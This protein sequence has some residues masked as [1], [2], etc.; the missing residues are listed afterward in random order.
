MNKP[1]IY[2]IDDLLFHLPQN[3]PE[4][5]NYRYTESLLPIIESIVE[6][7]CVTVTTQNLKN[8]VQLF[9]KN[10]FVLPNYFD[11]Y[12]WKLKKPT[13]EE[14]TKRP[15]IIGYMGT[16]THEED[17]QYITPVLKELLDRY[18]HEIEIHFWGVKPSDDLMEF[19]NIKWHSS[20]TYNYVEFANYFQN[21]SVDIFI[22]PLVDNLF[23]RS[24]SPLK[25]FEYSSLGTPSV[26][27]NLDPFENIIINKYNG[28][29]ASNHHEWFQQLSLLIEND[30]LRYTI[31]SNAQESIIE[32]WLL[33]KNI[34]KWKSLYE[35]IYNTEELF[36]KNNVAFSNL[37][38]SIN[39]QYSTLIQNF[40]DEN[41]IKDQIIQA[42]DQTIQ[43]ELFELNEIKKSKLWKIVLILRELRIKLLP[44]NSRREKLAKYF[45]YFLL[46]QRIK[47][48]NRRK[49]AILTDLLEV[50]R[51]INC[52]SVKQHKE[53]IDII[54]CV[55]NALDD[56]KVCLE[57]IKKYTS[58]PYSLIIV[59]DGSEKPTQAFLENSKY[60]FPDY[61]LIRND[62]AKGYTFAANMGMKVSKA[63]YLILLNS[64]TIVGPDWIDRLYR[65]ITLETKIGIV[66]TLSNTASWQ[67]IP[68]LENN[69]DWAKNL[70]P[71]SIS[72]EKMSQLVSN[73]SGC[74]Y[75]EVPLLNGFCLMIKKELINEIGY[76]DEE[77]F[78]Q[79]YGEEDDFN[80]RAGNAGWKKVIAD[81]VYV[82]HS[83]S[84][85][86]SHEAR[87]KLSAQNS[88]KLAKKHGVINI[89]N[90]V[91]QMNPNR[92]MEGIRHRSR[93]LLERE[94]II[95]QGNKHFNGRKILFVLP[96]IDAGGGANII[97][98][99]S[100][101]MRKMGVDV[102]IFNFKKFKPGFSQSY[103][104]L[105]VPVIYENEENL[106]L[107]GKEFDAVIASANYSVKW[108]QPL[109]NNFN[110]PILGY[111]IQD[112]EPM[113]YPNGSLESE[114]AKESYTM[115]DN[116]KCFTKTNWN[117]ETLLNGIGI[118]PNVV[119]ISVNIDLY[120]PLKSI[121][122]GLKP[123][124]IVA[125]IRPSSPYRNPDFTLSVLKKISN[126]YGKNVDIWLF[127]T[128]DIKPYFPADLLDF[129]W[130]QLGKLTQN[131]VAAVVSQADIFTDFSTYQAMGLTSLESL[132]CGSSVIVPQK[133]GSKEFVKHKYNGM[134]VDTTNFQ[135]CYES[136]EELIN[137]DQLRIE[138]QLNGSKDVVQYFPERAAFNILKSL[139]W[140]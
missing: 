109:Q 76:L 129:Q 32:K 83:Q 115:I 98:D 126:K 53:H 38:K 48:T 116:I 112:Y 100:R 34:G 24:K 134:I 49:K 95:S 2:D 131:Q 97:I 75:P 55:H 68:E 45:F 65:A 94:E 127:G 80:I 51:N 16:E 70:L 71:P 66:G 56:I 26:Y 36:S 121:E 17:I 69:G 19:V 123:T 62:V 137:N 61:K 40:K 59:D 27:S 52:H 107:L 28:L 64:D 6:A 110:K 84:K 113:M 130:K 104:N 72:V 139:F 21:Q 138:L 79:G 20:L 82:F 85:S 37:V 87:Y 39:D 41:N 120:R 22:A 4:R 23:N 14:R 105:D 54:V 1:I 117:Q 89:A 60:D 91:K 67:S 5:K 108:L 132:A 10:T 12:L 133:G 43:S 128:H 29:L 96:V 44:I 90:F 122:Y 118:K 124:T 93:I 9:N 103:P 99:E 102:Q 125:M 8:Q 7:D 63:E 88:E 78:G 92:I 77:N 86:Y 57:S 119:G 11:D 140:K 25:Y 136:L 46:G 74:T 73:Y 13:F 50:K 135:D 31:S 3:H 101:A 30:E 111:Y 42:K 35:K 106:G 47:I 18:L 114:K 58:E 15:I 33:S 81:D